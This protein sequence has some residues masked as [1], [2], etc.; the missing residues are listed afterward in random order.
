MILTRE[1]ASSRNA[2]RGIAALALV[3]ILAILSL[4]VVGMVLGGAR[5]QDLTVSRLETLRA[6][7]AAE[8]GAAM[9]IREVKA[10]ADYDGDGQIGG[11]SDDGN[12]T[13]N[14]TIGGARV[15]VDRTASGSG[16]T[17]DVKG[18][19]SVSRRNLQLA[20]TQAA[21]SAVVYGANP[22]STPV[23]RTWS[24]SAWSAPS[25]TL[26]IGN[27]P[28]WINVAVCPTRNETMVIASD[29]GKDVN[30]MV[31]NGS[32][33]GNLIE[34]C[35]DMGT[36]SDRPLAA[37]YEQLSGDALVVFRKGSS[38]DVYYRVWNGS[39]WSSESSTTTMSGDQSRFMRLV[40]K[41]GTD[42]IMLLTLDDREDLTGMVWN[43]SSWGSKVLLD[44]DCFTH[45]EEC[46][47]VAFES[48]SGD[49]LIVWS[50]DGQDTVR[51]RTWTSGGWGSD[52]AGPNIGAEARWIRLANDPTS[53]KISLLTLDDDRD[54]NAATWSGT[55]FGSATEFETGA[56]TNTKRGIAVA[57]EPAGTRAVAV[58]S[59]GTSTSPRYRVYDGSNWSSELTGP[60]LSD[61]FA[62]FQMAPIGTCQIILTLAITNGADRLKFMEWNGSSFIN[63][64]ELEDDLAGKDTHEACMIV[65]RTAGVPTVSSVV[66]VEP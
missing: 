11:V 37:A 2:R 7:Y 53:D 46:M 44:N 8:G 24:G 63:A 48:L 14:P 34:L 56:N 61:D 38:D 6:M 23:F 52:T 25:N 47:D 16:A 57:F 1:V 15:W 62:A 29:E 22:S 40:A 9:A 26:S 18:S 39:S 55:V 32:T 49:G 60:N 51:Y 54:V 65:S 5:D 30:A 66:A 21:P 33:W 13:N 10:N 43:G 41:P 17:L 36:K 12:S 19:T 35:T 50:R 64:V 59:E 28:R 27:K 45:S 20:V 58:Y 42:S 31:F 3:I 4:T